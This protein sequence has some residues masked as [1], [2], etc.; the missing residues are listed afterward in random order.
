MSA[1]VKV[2]IVSNMDSGRPF[3]EFTRPYGLGA[4]LAA[5]G[6]EVG[7]VGIDCT[8]ATFG[9]QWS[10]R[11]RSARAFAKAC[12]QAVREFRPDVV[13]AQQNRPA[14]IA[15]LTR[16]GVPVVADF[17]SLPSVEIEARPRGADLKR[18]L[19]DQT[20][21]TRA[22]V[23]ERLIARRADAIVSAGEA[24]TTAL[25]E[26]HR[27]AAEITTVPNGIDPS[28]AAAP[29]A[30]ESPYGPG[31]HAVATLPVDASPVNMR[32]LDF[33]RQVAAEMS[34]DG[35]GL[36]LDI[37]GSDLPAEPGIDF[38]GFVPELAPWLAGA[39]VCLL[40][41]PADAALSGAVRNKLLEYLAAGRT[42]VSTEE[43]MRGYEQAASW[44]GVTVT[45][46]DAGAFAAAVAQAADPAA[47]TLGEQR[48]ALRELTWES[49]SH[50]VRPV[51]EQAARR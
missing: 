5:N 45:S 3:G 48:A 35:A 8:A 27:P 51:L 19:H 28:L 36:T 6:L 31:R 39:D 1:A 20:E 25:R 7:N 22:F 29:D 18:R 23:F 50:R 42:I 40:P 15:I 13:Y 49:L 41:Y 4:G 14:A 26:R 10:T 34:A 17:H 9:P 2:L 24:V 37:V 46:D 11:N 21:R 32:A 38:H 16:P 12:R 47:P 30:G 44:A 43:G 33:L